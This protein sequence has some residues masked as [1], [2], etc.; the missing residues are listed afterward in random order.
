M[1]WKDIRSQIF[2][3]HKLVLFFNCIGKAESSFQ[4][5][6]LWLPWKPEVWHHS[7]ITLR[8]KSCSIW[9][10]WEFCHSLICTWDPTQREFHPKA[11]S[12]P[13]EVQKEG[14][15]SGSQPILSLLLGHHYFALCTAG[16]ESMDT[17]H[18][19]IMVAQNN[20]ELL[21]LGLC[22]CGSETH[23]GALDQMMLVIKEKEKKT[24][25]NKS[26]PKKTQNPQPTKK[27]PK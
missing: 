10:Q 12:S 20:L 14:D 13:K 6:F 24:Q 4:A 8:A 25:P 17:S 21:S 16:S 23:A 1:C 3:W 11:N 27:N 19:N 15:Q 22:S 9:S 5:L 18:E 26:C 2:R 7:N